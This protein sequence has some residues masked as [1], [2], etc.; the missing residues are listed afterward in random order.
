MRLRGPRCDFAPFERK[1]VLVVK[2]KI[3]SMEPWNIEE[4]IN[5]CISKKPRSRYAIIFLWYAIIFLFLSI[6]WKPILLLFN[7]SLDN[8]FLSP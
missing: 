4:G 7:K 3:Q 6:I 1:Q 5:P 2:E 8:N